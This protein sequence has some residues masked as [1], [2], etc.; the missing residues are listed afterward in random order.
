[1]VE[2]EIFGL[3]YKKQGETYHQ[4]KSCV[5]VSSLDFT[6]QEAESLYERFSELASICIKDNKSVYRA[7][8]KF[9]VS[10]DSGGG[11]ELPRD[12]QGRKIKTLDNSLIAGFH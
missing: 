3:W 5:I 2:L 4:Y 8:E 1:M 9:I 6:Q 7:T 11:I 10:I 12:H